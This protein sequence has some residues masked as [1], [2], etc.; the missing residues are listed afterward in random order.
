MYGYTYV[1]NVIVHVCSYIKMCLDN[2]Y[3]RLCMRVNV[4]SCV[5]ICYTSYCLVSICLFLNRVNVYRRTVV[6]EQVTY[7]LGRLTNSTQ[8]RQTLSNVFPAW[9]FCTGNSRTV[10]VYTLPLCVIRAQRV[11]IPRQCL[12]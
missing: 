1:R 12:T 2:S 8:R 9:P 5:N 4:V 3:V 6:N 11:I 7:L 10:P